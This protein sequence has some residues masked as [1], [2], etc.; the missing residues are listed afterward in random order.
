MLERI[1]SMAVYSALEPIPVIPVR[2]TALIVT[3]GP[4][5]SPNHSLHLR[6]PSHPYWFIV[7][8][9]DGSSPYVSDDISSNIIT[10]E[11]AEEQVL[12]RMWLVETATSTNLLSAEIVKSI[13]VYP[14]D[15]G[16]PGE[17]FFGALDL[18][19]FSRLDGLIR[20]F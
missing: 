12:I 8:S 7:I 15:L 6:I 17:R 14:C 2:D 13:P 1:K 19:A 10:C 4:P 20:C 5:V 11:N 9:I 16:C 3:D 18:S